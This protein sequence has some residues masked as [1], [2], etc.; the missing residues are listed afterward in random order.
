MREKTTIARPAKK[1]A[2]KPEL[3]APAGDRNALNA[4][5]RAGA[6]AVYFGLP[7]WNA[8]VRAV[9]FPLDEI[10]ETIGAVHRDGVRAYVTFNTLV[11]EGEEP[12]AHSALERLVAAR[13]DA[14]IVQDLGVARW[15]HNRYPDL[16]LHASTQMT[17]SSAEGILSMVRLGIRRV[18]LARELTI[19]EIE[20]IRDATVGK[21]ELEVFV[22][23]ALCISY[24]GQCLS[25]EAWG[26][27]SA[28]RGQC[29]QACRLPYD[30]IVDGALQPRGDR[31]YL[32]SPRDLEGIGQVPALMQMGIDGLKIEGRMKSAA[33]VA[34][35]T[36]AYR[37]ALDADWASLDTATIQSMS[38]DARKV[39]SR[40]E[41]TG[42]LGGI[43]HQ[44]LVDGRTRA[45]RGIRLGTVRSVGQN[46][47]EIHLDP[48]MA[49]PVPGDGVLFAAGP[50]ESQET[51]GKI[52][53]VEVLPASTVRLGFGRAGGPDPAHAPP[54]TPVHLT[55]DT[56]LDGELRRLV[57]DPERRKRIPLDCEVEGTAEGPLIVTF[58][59]SDGNVVRTESETPLQVADRHPLDRDAIAGHL[60]RLGDS[61]Y[62]LRVLRIRL[63][64]EVAIPV[65]EMNL[66]RRRAIE[67]LERLRSG[68][69]VR[70]EGGRGAIGYTSA[71]DPSPIETA[72][73]RAGLAGPAPHREL[74]AHRGTRT[75]LPTGAGQPKD[76]L[77]VL[78]RTSEQVEGAIAAGAGRIVLDFLDLV[79]MRGAAAAV[80]RSGGELSVA[81]PRIQKPGEE[82]ILSFLLGLEPRAVLVRNLA[83]LEHLSRLH[84][85]GRPKLVGD[86][87]LNAVNA[88]AIEFLVEAGCDRVTPGFDLDDA[89]IVTLVAACD[90]T[91]LEIL[92]HHH[93][94]LFHTEHCVFAGCLSNGADWRTCGK[95]CDRHKIRLRDRTGVEHAVIADVGCRNTVFNA[96]AHNRNRI[97]KKL[98]MA[99]VLHNRI[100]M[101]EEDAAATHD[102]VLRF[103]DTLGG[104]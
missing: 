32:L 68:P 42:F 52:Y 104:A 31:A 93:L 98:R 38:L 25:S 1:P 91:R 15:L 35:S 71:M 9:N 62:A 44:E 102:L 89:Q 100:E 16:P 29:A 81:T 11:F 76:P 17:I 82:L 101:L 79:G 54:G 47:I 58:R 84:D 87:T 43:N 56:K 37:R 10:E 39:F 33:Y 41:S 18:I 50:H 61:R 30:L 83:S 3:L 63:G 78:C 92:I 90:A 5:I 6:D 4:A 53:T 51:G 77:V 65:R 26:G 48:A 69:V 94:P 21:V 8:R 59:D 40:G 36:R 95:P 45:H 72:I 22:H 19:P 66:M 57:H 2:A 28:N 46:G 67:E 27:R 75:A 7:D 55:H 34:A 96:R 88:R 24:S 12:A 80:H 86:T 73:A 13:P 49:A 70:Q 60:G 20:R 64:G 103:R 14:I 97:L 99:G 74:S 85:A 23:G